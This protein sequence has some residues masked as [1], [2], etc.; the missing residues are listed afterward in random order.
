MA[1]YFSRMYRVLVAL[2]ALLALLLA[3]ADG[4]TLFAKHHRYLDGL[5]GY[6]WQLLA[7][8]TL[9]L[10]VLTVVRRG[11]VERLAAWTSVGVIGHQLYW[12][13]PLMPLPSSPPTSQSEAPQLRIAAFNVL[14]SNRRA[15]ETVSYF[16]E[17]DPDVIGCF[18]S[19]KHW[20][21]AL[22]ELTDTW[23][24]HLRIDDLDMDIFSKDPIRDHQVHRIGDYRGFV[25]CAIDTERQPV[26]VILNHTHPPVT[27]GEQG[28]VWRNDQLAALAERYMDETSPLV[29]LG[30]FNASTWSPYFRELLKTTGWHHA[31]AARLPLGTHSIL[32]PQTLCFAHPIDHALGNGSARLLRQ[33]IGPYLG[34]DHR[35]IVV[36]VALE[37]AKEAAQES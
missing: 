24:H 9:L 1:A 29:V 8:A 2:C 6:R 7:G 19:I 4:L 12:I 21:S 15:A 27:F 14:H 35:P 28:F 32:L 17:I 23:S 22:Y 26:T 31:P 11:S 10:A 16:R 37:S 30:D 18:E 36:D 33:T 25:A 20:P 13:L 5:T 3:T 34:S